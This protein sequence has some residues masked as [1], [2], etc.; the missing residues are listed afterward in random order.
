MEDIF[1]SSESAILIL[2]DLLQYENLDAGGETHEM[3]PEIMVMNER[4]CVLLL[5]TGTFSLDQNWQPLLRLLAG[6]LKWAAILAG[7][8][9]DV[10]YCMYCLQFSFR[11]PESLCMFCVWAAKNR[12]S[13]TV[14]D[15]T[16]ASEFGLVEKYSG[17][18][19]R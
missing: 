14:S 1:S 2:N 6:K 17:T 16:L 9:W 4:F 10:L 19:N 7:S 18:H 12:V 5:T 8:F 11:T 3:K 13:L 15:S